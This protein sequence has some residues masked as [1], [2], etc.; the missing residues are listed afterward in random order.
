VPERE[1]IDLL[2]QAASAPDWQHALVAL[3]RA[4]TRLPMALR[5]TLCLGSKLN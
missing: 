2:S 5:P 3:L 4:S 1:A